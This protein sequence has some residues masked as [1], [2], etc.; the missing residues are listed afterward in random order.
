MCGLRVSNGR[1]AVSH[2]EPGGASSGSSH[3]AQAWTR[4]CDHTVDPKH[5][6][7]GR[8]ESRGAFLE[9]RTP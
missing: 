7:F 1:L 9:S 4:V 8:D 6:F 5:T 2:A 3:R